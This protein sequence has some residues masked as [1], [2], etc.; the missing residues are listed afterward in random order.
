[1][2]RISRMA[3]QSP[4]LLDL[5]RA[6]ASRQTRRAQTLLQDHPTIA[7]LPLTIGASRGDPTDFFLAPI[8]H[9]AYAG[10]TALH[11]AAAAYD[12]D[13]VQTLIQLRANPH[14]RNRRGAE[15]IHYAAD[16]APGSPHWNPDAQSAVIKLLIQAGA[17]PNAKDKSGTAPLH[18]AVRTRCA[19]AVM[20]LLDLGADP[21]LTNGRGSTPLDLAQRTTG[22]GGSGS[23]EA[24]AEQARILQLLVRST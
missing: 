22:R 11:I 6:I 4:A 16:G 21:N 17:A 7:T 23:P 3:P 20:T 2:G 13:L 19:Q 15:P 12:T 1:M 5:F 8:G 9:Y 18:R 10:D 14:A 24:R